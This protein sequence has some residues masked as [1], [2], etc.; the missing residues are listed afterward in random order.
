MSFLPL[1]NIAKID[2][3]TDIPKFGTVI[4]NNDPEKLGRIKVKLT[5][6][7]EP[8]DEIGSN[9]PWV[10]QLTDTFLCG[11]NCE[12][13]SVPEIG[14][15]VEIKWAFDNRTPFYTGTPY[16]Q[17]HKT[18][19]F[20]ENYP[21]EAGMQF[22]ELTLKFDKGNKS[23]VITNNKGFTISADALGD[24]T[25]VGSSATLQLDSDLDI[26]V[27][28][29]NFRGNVNIDGILE[30]STGAN[31]LITAANVANVSNGIVVGIE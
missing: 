4:Y 3:N 10:R 31:G 18:N 7:F 24:I 9:L 16:S 26:D 8:T 23:I 13:F 22:G 17:K 19:N 2:N 20:T 30:C 15:V 21:Y 12:M 29:T 11:N 14:S 6:I 27:P 25:I 28:N 5:G 1:N